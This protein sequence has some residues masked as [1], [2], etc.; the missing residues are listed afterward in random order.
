MAMHN[1]V[2]PHRQKRPCFKCQ[3]PTG[4]LKNG[5]I[6]LHPVCPRCSSDM[7]GDFRRALLQRASQERQ[8]RRGGKAVAP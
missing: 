7:D 3:E 1:A 6:V 5:Q 2:Q 4:C 8:S